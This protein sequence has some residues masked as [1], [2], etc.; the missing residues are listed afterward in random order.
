[1]LEA[2]RG[3]MKASAVRRRIEIVLLPFGHARAYPR[4]GAGWKPG[5]G[6]VDT[7]RTPRYPAPVT[8]TVNG[9]PREIPDGATVAEL[10]AL[11]AVDAVGVAV[12]VNERI[13]RKASHA[14]HRLAAADQVE[15]VTFVGGG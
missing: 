9:D 6:A 10:L 12:E 3:M 5:L 4:L 1:M 15:I 7:K 8:L 14:H 11:L 13:V 2:R